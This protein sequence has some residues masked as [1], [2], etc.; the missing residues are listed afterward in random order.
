VT[1]PLRPTPLPAVLDH[2]GFGVVEASDLGLPGAPATAVML[3]TRGVIVR[4]EDDLHQ[5]DRRRN[6]QPSRR[7]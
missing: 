2:K 6:P 1:R 3:P 7:L 5:A 4:C